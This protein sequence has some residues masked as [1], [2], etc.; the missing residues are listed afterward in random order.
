M[1]D[2]GQRALAALALDAEQ[3]V[4]ALVQL[5]DR[6]GQLPPAPA[7]L[8]GDLG[9]AGGDHLLVLLGHGDDVL[10]GD[11][12]IHDE[13]QL[14]CAHVRIDLPLAW[15]SPASRGTERNRRG[16][17]RPSARRLSKSCKEPRAAAASAIPYR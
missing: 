7:L 17:N 9:A 8:L 13:H 16:A 6:I 12:R 15:I 5:G 2:L 4:L 10:V 1:L 14:V 3:D 11:A